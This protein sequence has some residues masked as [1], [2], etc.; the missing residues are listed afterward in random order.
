MTMWIGGLHEIMFETG[1]AQCHFAPSK[2]FISDRCYFSYYYWLALFSD[3]V[4][5]ISSTISKRRYSWWDWYAFPANFPLNP[6][7]HANIA[8]R[9]LPGPPRS[10]FWKLAMA[11]GNRVLFFALSSFSNGHFQKR[12][13]LQIKDKTTS[14]HPLLLSNMSGYLDL[15]LHFLPQH[16]LS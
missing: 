9:L 13:V 1:W 7:P 4:P 14:D 8:K 6:T 15:K 16:L 3:L 5:T 11:R 10:N 12:K 2:S